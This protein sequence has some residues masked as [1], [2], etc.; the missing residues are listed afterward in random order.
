MVAGVD[1]LRCTLGEALNNGVNRRGSVVGRKSTGNTGKGCA[2]TSQGM[3]AGSIK[4]IR[5]HGDDNYIAGIRAKMAQHTYENDNRGNQ[6]FRGYGQNLFQRSVDIAGAIGDADTQ[7]GYDNHAQRREA[8]IVGNHFGQQRYE[9]FATEHIVY[10]DFLAG[11][12]VH[13]TKVHGG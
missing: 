7:S 2:D 3:L 8:G 12:R 11:G 6:K 10:N 13:I 5:S 9:V 4:H 1:D